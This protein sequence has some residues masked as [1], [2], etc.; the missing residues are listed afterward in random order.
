MHKLKELT[1]WEKSLDLAVETYQMTSGFPKDEVY[2]LTQQIKRAVISIS[3]NIAEGA[4]RNGSNEFVH[5]LGISNGSAYELQTQIIL[6]NRLN[7]ID[8]KSS[9]TL[10][11]KIDEIQKMI[12]GL[13]KKIKTT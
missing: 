8:N 10:L 9:E 6:A 13:I 4:G 5:F 12:Y 7:L 1:V 11:Q 3:S 2:G